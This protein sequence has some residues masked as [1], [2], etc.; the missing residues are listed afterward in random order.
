MYT[1]TPAIASGAVK[2]TF[3]VTVP[4]LGVQLAMLQDAG[5]ASPSTT[6]PSSQVSPASILPLPQL[7]LHSV[8]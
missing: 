7:A 4:P 1:V 6:L 8:S 3:T 5:Q 2:L